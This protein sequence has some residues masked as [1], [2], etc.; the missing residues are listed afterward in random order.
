[1]QQEWIGIK[2]KTPEA[3]QEVLITDGVFI[4]I[5]TWDGRW[6]EYADEN[7]THW[8]PL[9]EP[10]RRVVR[11]KIL[12]EY[13]EKVIKGEKNFELRKD[14]D[15]CMIGDK[16]TQPC[17]HC[18]NYDVCKLE[19]KDKCSSCGF[20]YPTK[21]REKTEAYKFGY[22]KAI[23]DFV[24]HITLPITTEEQISEIVEQLKMEN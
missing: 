1:M 13:F 11:K 3:D 7:V 16:I 10:P 14:E 20:V 17:E 8:M 24:E 9:P 2:E 5:D 6:L 19:K 4:N 12:P 15:G 21:V 22:N 18:E 23:D